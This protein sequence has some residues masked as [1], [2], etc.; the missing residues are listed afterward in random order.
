MYS[1]TTKLWDIGGKKGWLA[2]DAAGVRWDKSFVTWKFKDDAAEG[3]TADIKVDFWQNQKDYSVEWI[4]DKN[5][6]CYL[7]K[8]GGNDHTDLNNKKHIQPKNVVVQ[9]QK[10]SR[11]NDGYEGNVHMIYGTIGKGKAVIFQNGNAIKGQ[12]S[13]L[14]RL[15]RTKFSDEA[16]KEIE[17]VKGQ[18]WI[19]T[20]PEGSSVAY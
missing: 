18:I 10:E 12:W 9:Y 8:N 14:N 13:K 17:F 1:T 16:G 19:Q 6:N 2:T 20:V 7:R 15:G 4:Y 11:A 3:A 5:C